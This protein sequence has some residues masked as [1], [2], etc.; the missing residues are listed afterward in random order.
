MEQKQNVQLANVEAELKQLKDLQST[1]SAITKACLF[2]LIIYSHEPRRTA[3]FQNIVRLIISH[4]PCRVIFIQT[5]L[6]SQ[7]SYLRVNVSIEV[8]PQNPGLTCD[9]ICLEASENELHRVPFIVLPLIVTDLPIYLLWGQD[10][11]AENI[12]LPR[13]QS[14]ANRLIF[15]S[16]GSQ[17]L[18][19][20]AKDLL[21][22]KKSSKIEIVDIN[23]ARIEGWREVLNQT[24]DSSE[25]LQQLSSA[26]SMK[27]TYNNRPS[28][29]FLQTQTQA[30][31]LQAWL[32]TQMK[33]SFKHLDKDGLDILLAYQT[34]TGLIE[35]RLQGQPRGNIPSEE[36]LE[37]EVTDQSNFLYS[38]TRKDQEQ[39]IVYCNTMDR[40][41]LPFTLLLPNLWS[42]KIFIPEVFYQPTSEQY[43]N[44]LNIIAHISWS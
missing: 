9:Q 34:A 1:N 24:F 35:I 31:Y 39:V 42:G 37:I 19:H 22:R 32:A 11:S 33:W 26:K 3:Y 44:M 17:N 28:D 13:L 30:I 41:E 43:F 15:D 6:H 5:E 23:W 40:C 27:I 25:R 18:Q 4:F 10:P 36:I 8:N 38:I 7:T 2:N 21:Q 16:E 29:L 14:L 12:V 20:F